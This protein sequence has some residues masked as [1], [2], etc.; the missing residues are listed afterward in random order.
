MSRQNCKNNRYKCCVARTLVNACVQATPRQ[1][2]LDKALN[3]CLVTDYAILYLPYDSVASTRVCS[4]ST[5]CVLHPILLVST[6]TQ[7]HCVTLQ[8]VQGI[9]PTP[10]PSIQDDQRG[11]AGAPLWVAG[12]VLAAGFACSIAWRSMFG[13]SPDNR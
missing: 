3:V 2:H 13:S 7:G 8:Y 12:L 10:T 11:P 5:I 4:Y 6:A 1:L 9:S